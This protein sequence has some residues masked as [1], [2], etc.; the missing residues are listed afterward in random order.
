MSQRRPFVIVLLAVFAL[1]AVATGSA[2]AARGEKTPE[3]NPIGSFTD[4]SVGE[5][6][7]IAKGLLGE[8]ALK[9]PDALSTG[10]FQTSLLG[11][12]DILFLGCKVEEAGAKLACEGL[13]DTNSSSVLWLGTFHLRYQGSAHTTAVLAYLII[14]VHLTCKTSGLEALIEV[15]GC[16]AGQVGPTNVEIKL[17]ESFVNTLKATGVKNEITTIENEAGTGEESC[18]LEAKEGTGAFAEASVVATDH[19]YPLTAASEIIT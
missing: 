8:E 16:M 2:F 10:G 1:G 11:T 17:P 13:N 3:V 14:P 9:C 5:N 12:F 7:F 15:K 4:Q 6:E 19:I 18:K